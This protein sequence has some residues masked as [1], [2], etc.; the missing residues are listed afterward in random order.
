[1][2]ELSNLTSS[3]ETNLHFNIAA[4]TNE[5]FYA[6]LHP[7]TH[8]ASK[9]NTVY[10]SEIQKSAEFISTTEVVINKET[11]FAQDSSSDKE[12]DRIESLTS[13]FHEVE[14]D[15]KQIRNYFQLLKSFKKDTALQKEY[16][17]RLVSF[18]YQHANS[19]INVQSGTKIPVQVASIQRRKG[20]ANKQSSE[21][22]KENEDP[23]E[24]QPRK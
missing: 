11:S 19:P 14:N 9:D 24:M 17:N 13:F 23:H 4:N 3:L 12:L 8:I 20:V 21:K 5:S 16:W 15:I 18:V 2:A 22:G 1:M 6:S 10:Q 7:R